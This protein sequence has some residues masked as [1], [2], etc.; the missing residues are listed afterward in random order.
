MVTMKSPTPE[1]EQQ[2]ANS[3]RVS[4]EILSD[5]GLMLRVG[6]GNQL[7][8]QTL[9]GRHLGPSLGMATR[10]LA[11]AAEAEEIM[12]EAFLRLW[13]H[14]PNWSPQGAKFTTWFY[15]VVMNLCIDRQRTRR[16]T[17][18]PI[19]VAGDPADDRQGAD[20]QLHESQVGDQVAQ[21][22]ATLPERQRAAITLCYLQGLSN[23]EA[24]EILDVNIKALE[25]LLTRGRR[26]LKDQLSPLKDEL[27]G[28]EQ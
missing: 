7:A 23:K 17:M 24:A 13:R 27:M 22:I 8:Y 19:E 14:A 4:L 6:D 20:S 3:A 28:F 12:Q 2:A 18:V 5:E 9:V 11:N 1:P 21:A 25:S 26:A 15:R 10:V 16:A